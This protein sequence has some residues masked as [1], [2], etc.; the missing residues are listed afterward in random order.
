MRAMRT[1]LLLFLALQFPLR[2]SGNVEDNYWRLLTSGVDTN[3]RGISADYEHSPSAGGRHSADPG[4]VVIW[5]CGSNGVI[6]RSPDGGKKWKRLHVEGGDTLDFRGIRSF[7][8]ATAYVMSVGDNGRSRIYK[9]TNRGETWRLQYSD[10]RPEF[11]LDGL[12]C[13][14]KKECFAISDPIDGMFVL[15]QTK[16][17]ERWTELPQDN[18]PAALP[19]EGVFAASNSALALCGH[20]ELF[21]G[22]GGPVA[23]V[24]YSADSGHTWT[25]RETPIVSGNPSSG[26]FSLRCYGDT[27]VAVGGDYLKP[28][29]PSRVA[30]YSFDHGATWK[31]AEPG[32]D[33]FRSGVEG[34]FDRWNRVAVG[35]TGTDISAN[36]GVQWQRVSSLNLNAIFV[37]DEALVLAAGP[38][39]TVAQYNSPYDNPE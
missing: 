28:T 7:G 10:K 29:Q 9:T 8:A 1:C 3:L 18:I 31:L 26:V 35:P 20:N 25:A 4:A 30:A 16:D 22:T 13:R 15:L 39:G 33:G 2:L 11:F 27:I 32:P 21:F 24:F 38:S 36:Q 34:H 17:G 23:R 37:L 19:K 12:V 6:L 5:V 14:S